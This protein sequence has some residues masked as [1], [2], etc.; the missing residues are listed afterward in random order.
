MMLLE[1]GGTRRDQSA[2]DMSTPSLVSP[3]KKRT[4]DNF[5]KIIKGHTPTKTIHRQT[6]QKDRETGQN[7][8]TKGLYWAMVLRDMMWLDH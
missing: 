1:P 6:L 3:I 2:A 5:S 4:V 8:I 7:T